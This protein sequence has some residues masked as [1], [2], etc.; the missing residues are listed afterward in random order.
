[1]QQEIEITDDNR[2][3]ILTG[4]ICPYCGDDTM[5]VEGTEI[6]GSINKRFF[7]ICWLCDAYVGTHKSR[8]TVAL[9]RLANAELRQWKQEAHAWFDP[10]WQRKGT[11]EARSKYYGWLSSKMGIPKPF[12]HIEMFDVE[13]CKQV[14][15]LCKEYYKQAS[16]K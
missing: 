6:Y 15:A 5:L 16:A 11:N 8:Y 10:I 14:V 13:Q 7:Y 1:M 4:K 2:L 12:A 3:E 9:G